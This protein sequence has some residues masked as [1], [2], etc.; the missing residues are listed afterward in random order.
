MCDRPVS[1]PAP[2]E[3][4]SF[5]SSLGGYDNR[6]VP[7]LR[8]D[9]LVI[10][11]GLAGCTAALTAADD[12][13]S[14][15][16]LTKTPFSETNSAYAQGG[17]AAVVHHDDSPELHLD[18][19]L[20][21]GAG[22]S[23]AKVAAT[24]VAEGTDVLSWLQ[25][26][27]VDFDRSAAGDLLLSREGGHS[28]N[29]VVHKGDATGIA[30]SGTV[31]AA[32]R[33]HPN[34]TCRT[35]AFV[36]DLLVDQGRC[37]GAVVHID[38]A[39]LAIEAIATIVATGGAGQVYRETTN[40]IGASGD[41]VALCFRAGATITDMEFVQFHPT[42]LYIA[43]A[44]RFLIS[45]VVR[46][47]GA[48]LRDRDGIRFMQD[49]HPSAELAP[50]DVVSRAILQRMVDTGDTHV[51]LDLSA[52]DAAHQRFPTISRIC[53]AFDIDIEQD[54]IPV[55][56]G[57]HYFMGGASSD[58]CG[59]TDVPGLLVA[60]E[61]AATGFHGAN[62]LASNSLLEGAVLGRRAGA[63][64]ARLA[65]EQSA[66]LPKKTAGV[67][68]VANAPRIHLD[69]MLYSLKSLMWRNVG[70]T[71]HAEGLEEASH[72]IG[73]WHHYL[74]R[75]NPSTS[76]AFEL[77]NM[78]LVSALVTT[79]A[80]ERNESRGTHYRSDFPERDDNAWCRRVTL[81]RAE[82]GSILTTRRPIS[83]PSDQIAT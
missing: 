19:T 34:I 3:P 60:G 78:L 25:T 1:R 2:G 46:G 63:T 71:R 79:A 17:L 4:P 22:L 18:D 59:Q 36:R 54:A 56:P 76:A 8:T 66:G 32:V 44:S 45:E 30:I 31:E 58:M 47:A 6:V 81:Q 68:R 50:R 26:L 51:Y 39:E 83:A 5:P 43:G 40:P 7:S 80:Q 55:R 74:M 28:V 9:V 33:A 24:I 35:G 75:A 13:A 23:D 77:A 42:T 49:V 57:A 11:A 65:R 16:L 62:R 67:P 73:L 53:R 37:S 41:G 52:V 61:A 27:G 15:L 72:R 21:V 12:G 14:V 82:D 29:R 64:A 69:D 20:R 70:L 38:G 10:G 48:M